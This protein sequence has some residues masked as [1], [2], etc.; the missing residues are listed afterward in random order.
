VFVKKLVVAA[1]FAA[2]CLIALATQAM[3]VGGQRS[4]PPAA[5]KLATLVP[6]QI[7]AWR[8]SDGNFA[9]VD[10][11]DIGEERTAANSY[12]QIVSRSYIHPD[13]TEIILTLAYGRVQE[14][15]LK[16]HSPELCYSAQGFLLADDRA[17]RLDGGRLPGRTFVAT[18]PE[19]NEIVAYWVRIGDVTTSTSLGVRLALLRLGVRHMVPDGILVRGSIVSA[20]VPNSKDSRTAEARLAD[21]LD[22]VVRA[23]PASQR[24]I[25]V[26]GPHA[27]AAAV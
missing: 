19:R 10:P 13:G 15:E 3:W 2:A 24:W 5:V 12:D 9:A 25:L 18:R 20:G 14:Q 6:P 17:I 7:G 26:G 23:V 1:C 27:I 22:A 11:G 4:V 16:I 21:F 8:E